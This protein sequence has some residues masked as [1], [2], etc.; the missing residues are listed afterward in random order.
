MEAGEA[1]VDL[2]ASSRV[3]APHLHL[4]LQSGSDS[5][6]RRMRRGMTRARFRALLLRAARANARIH[7]ATDVIAGFPGETDEEFAETEALLADLPLASLHVFPFSPRSGTAA[8]ALAETDAVPAALRTRRAA[9][10]R[11]LDAALRRRYAEAHDGRDADVV[12]LRGGVGL[13]GTYVE[14]AL[15]PDGPP[16]ASR[17]AATLALRPDGRLEARAAAPFSC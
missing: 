12:A 7:L 9:H 8:A 5:V 14:V 4:P 15:P 13:T 3:V 6:L 17:F 16:P 2:V 10:L 1:L 11:S